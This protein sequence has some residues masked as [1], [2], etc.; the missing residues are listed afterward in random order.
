MSKHTL[1]TID[2]FEIRTRESSSHFAAAYGNSEALG[3]SRADF[4]A[5]CNAF[6]KGAR[7]VKEKFGGEPKAI[8]FTDEADGIA[9]YNNDATAILLP[10]SFIAGV[11]RGDIT[12]HHLDGLDSYKPELDTR[13]EAIRTMVK[14]ENM[15]RRTAMFG[16]E[17]AYHHVQRSKF[18]GSFRSEDAIENE[19]RNIVREAFTDARFIN[20][21]SAYGNFPGRNSGKLIVPGRP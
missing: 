15:L 21:E 9:R 16:V 10:R 4:C 17:E 5:F 1:G 12:N 3:I 11:M 6:A 7:Y 8:T 19:V 13:M 20:W 18:M 14:R 2:D